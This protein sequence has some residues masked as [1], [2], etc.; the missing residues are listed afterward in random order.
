MAA[1]SAA[2]ARPASENSTTAA[3]APRP[4]A[5]RPSSAAACTATVQVRTDRG[6]RSA[7]A[8]TMAIPARLATPRA[9]RT[10]GIESA[11]IPLTSVTNVVMYVYAT[12]APVVP[13]VATITSSR[14]RRESGTAPRAACPSSALDGGNTA[15]TVANAARPTTLSARKATRHPAICPSHVAAG[16]AAA[17]PTVLPA[18]TT[19]TARPLSSGR[20]SPAAVGTTTAQNRAC[21]AA[22]TMRMAST[23]QTLSASAAMT[24]VATNPLSSTDSSGRRGTVRVST[25]SGMV[26][27]TTTAP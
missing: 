19:A 23:S 6:Q 24:V 10:T 11:A 27:S 22:P 25:V 7:I 5:D 4:H 26:A 18:K 14:Y 20:N 13:R 17:R 9:S 1:V 3:I 8:A 12:R 15:A 16:S 2:K 21:V